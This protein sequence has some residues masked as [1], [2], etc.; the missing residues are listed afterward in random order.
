VERVEIIGNL[1][2]D[3]E[4]RTTQSGSTVCSF[5]VAVNQPPTKAQREAGQ[6]PSAKFFRVSAWETLGDNC[7]KYLSK[8]RKVFVAGTIR[9]NAYM[10]SQD[11]KPHASLEI[12][13][14]NVEFLS[15]RGD[16][17]D[18]TSAGQ[19]N[20]APAYQAANA[21]PQAASEVPSGFTAVDTDELPF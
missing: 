2:A 21:V 4:T 5:T 3:P 19:G 17:G 18:N 15:P 20:N 6:Q 11:N 9:A 12:T 7:Q 8:G 16:Q 14:L 13:A 10:G 1:T